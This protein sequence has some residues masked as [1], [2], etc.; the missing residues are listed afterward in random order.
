MLQSMKLYHESRVWFEASLAI[1]EEVSGKNSINTATLLF[2]LSQALALDK[3]MRAAV[4]RMRESFNIFNTVLGPEDRNTKE[5][6]HWLEQLTQSAVSQAKQLQD[7]AKGR[8]QRVQLGGA[9]NKLK[10]QASV[11]QTASEATTPARP[12]NP[13]GGVDQR[14]ID[15]LL[16]YIEGGDAPKT[17]SSKKRPQN[18]KRRIRA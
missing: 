4:N 14:S 12:R 2:Q 15:E 13:A 6:E 11:G 10:P 5:A 17:A 16:R 18:P 1:C 3:D 7:L 9:R 8:L